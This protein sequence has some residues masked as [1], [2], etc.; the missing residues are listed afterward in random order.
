MKKRMVVGFAFQ[1]YDLVW[2]IRKNRPD[3]QKGLLNGIGG[4][5]EEGE[6]PEGAMIREF[7][8]EAGARVENWTHVAVLE[9]N[10]WYLDVFATQLDTK[11]EI[12]TMT[13]EKV[14]SYYIHR[15]FFE[16]TLPN[17][18]FLVPMCREHLDNEYTFLSAHLVY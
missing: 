3:F 6:T 12:R 9:G 18:R 2:L 8:E 14:D 7:E 11:C 15:L 1:H 16:S 4:H 17:V 10:N 13:D 5:V